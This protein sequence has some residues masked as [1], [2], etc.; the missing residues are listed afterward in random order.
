MHGLTLAAMARAMAAGELTATELTT[1]LLQ[2]VETIGRDLNAFI[3]VTAES[4]L[5]EAA[6]ADAA[7]KAGKAGRLCGLP[8]VHKDLFCTQGVRTTC[9]SKMLDN[10]VSPYDAAVV[11]RLKNAG[12]IMLGKT[13]MDEFAMGSSNETSFF[14]PVKNPWDKS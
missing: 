6:A 11:E 10:F 12:A 14:G 2:R 4:A 1:K 7:R 9:G 8:I 13:N 5:S 3:S